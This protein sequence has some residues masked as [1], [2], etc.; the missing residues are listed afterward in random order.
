MYRFS[1]ACIAFLLLW[2]PAL[3]A[4]H[5]AAAPDGTAATQ[6]H[7]DQLFTD[8]KRERN[9]RAAQRIA[10]R[11]REE[12]TRSGSATADLMMQWAADAMK[13][14]K[15]NVALDFLDQVVTLYPNYA[16]GWNRRATVHFLMDNYGLSMTDISRTLRLE[17][18]HFGALSG[19]AGIM[20]ETGRPEQALQA[21]RRVL[22]IYP[23]MRSAQG[24]VARLSDQLTG[25][26][27]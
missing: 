3:G 22:E 4:E 12:W 19:M 6:S 23:M 20:K 7:L 8:L 26:G 5:N 13:D 11:I 14:K 17:P 18:R 25:E 24:E 16:E 10:N 21:Y 9:E 2:T 1:A 27:I 15:Y